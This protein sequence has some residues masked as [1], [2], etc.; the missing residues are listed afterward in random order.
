MLLTI[1]ASGFSEIT[2]PPNR[3]IIDRGGGQLGGIVV[4]GLVFNSGIYY[5]PSGGFVKLSSISNNTTVLPYK[6]PFSS[7]LMYRIEG[8]GLLNQ[9][10]FIKFNTKIPEDAISTI[11]TDPRQILYK[12][13]NKPKQGNKPGGNNPRNDE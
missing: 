1:G 12:Y 3:F 7:G 5:E 2:I 8:S 4:S 6:N 11:K 13:E 10:N 9:S